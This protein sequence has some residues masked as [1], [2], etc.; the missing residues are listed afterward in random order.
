MEENKQNYNII[1]I[2]LKKPYSQ[3]NLLKVKKNMPLGLFGQ[4]K[5]EPLYRKRGGYEKFWERMVSKKG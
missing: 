3:E 2:R 5:R 1:T 4:R